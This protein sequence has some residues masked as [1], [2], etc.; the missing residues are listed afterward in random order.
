MKIFKLCYSQ[1]LSDL[2]TV[3]NADGLMIILFSLN[4]F[5]GT[6]SEP[7]IQL[8]SSGFVKKHPWFSA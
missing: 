6:F 1:F 4:F 3:L 2:S 7:K 8:Q 5:K